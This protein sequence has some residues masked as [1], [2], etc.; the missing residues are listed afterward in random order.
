MYAN[1]GAIHNFV[2]VD[3]VA[4]L[5][6]PRVT[7]SQARPDPWRF[8][9]FPLWI[10]FFAMG[11]MPEPVYILLRELA[12]VTTQRAWVNSPV[13]ITVSFAGFMAWF[14]FH[15]CRLAGLSPAEIRGNALQIGVLGLVAFLALPQSAFALPEL[16]LWTL[17]FHA[18]SI[19]D[20]YLRKVVYMAA[21]TKFGAWLYLFSLVFRYGILGNDRAFATIRGLFPSLYRSPREPDQIDMDQ[22]RSV[23]TLGPSA[24]CD[25]AGDKQGS[26]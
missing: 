7:D 6:S 9:A 24:A 5:G 15:Q 16:G 18:D 4:L 13:A 2:S 25:K 14:T 20:P 23:E 22:A 17:V 21:I 11:L 10:V 19:P 1:L 3:P 8:A 26:P 12:G